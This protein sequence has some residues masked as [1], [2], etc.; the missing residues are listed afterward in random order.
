LTTTIAA[1]KTHVAKFTKLLEA[2]GLNRH[3]AQLE[4]QLNS[5]LSESVELKRS[6]LENIRMAIVFVLDDAEEYLLQIKGDS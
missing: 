6:E 3:C 4:R 2:N 1:L 5:F